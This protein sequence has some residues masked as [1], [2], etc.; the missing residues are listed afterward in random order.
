MTDWEKFKEDINLSQD[1]ASNIG[2]GL[3]I[4]FED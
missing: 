4:K 2:H 3:S 1:N